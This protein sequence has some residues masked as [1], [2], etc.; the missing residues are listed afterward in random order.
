MLLNG[1][2]ESRDFSLSNVVSGLCNIR[3]NMI[4]NNS[5]PVYDG[6]QNTV[7]GCCAAAHCGT[8]RRHRLA[9]TASRLV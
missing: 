4:L 3:L 2:R 1:G 7:P 6:K 8:T 5:H 9:V